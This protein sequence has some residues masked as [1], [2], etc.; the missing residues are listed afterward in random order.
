VL[1]AGGAGYIGSHAAKALAAA[2]FEPVVFD[3]LS[4]GHE[5]AV[6][7]GPLVEASLADRSAI[8]AALNRYDP[9]AV[10]HFA[11]HAYV[12]E[13]VAH[14][15]KYYRN[16]VANTMNLLDAALAHGGLPIVFSSTCA[17]YG[18]PQRLPIDEA[19]PQ[20]PINPYGHTKL[21]VEEM[22][23]AYDAAYGLRSVA[24][25][26]F[27]AA[28]ADPD[29]ELGEEHDDETHLVPLALLTSLGRR[30]HLDVFG[31]DYGTRD[32]TAVRDYIHVSDLASAHVH[33][34]RYLL[35]GGPTT[36]LNLGVGHGYS[37]RDVIDAVERVTGARVPT[38]ERPRRAGDPPALVAD[39]AKARATLGWRP[40][41]SHL[42]EIVETAWRWLRYRRDQDPLGEHVST[43]P[44]A[45]V[46]AERSAA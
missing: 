45:S 42:D 27:N 8:E 3:D 30:P 17:T 44:P 40:E 6:R 4:T 1:V 38:V 23:T 22:L 12:G 5:H 18:I 35:D 7:W 43:T 24:L 31:S 32:G 20:R 39:A 37:V 15:A 28:G 26:Y 14:P 9:V 10:I 19:H 34:L 41:H 13:S 36:A 21:V 2:D 11:A 29:G 25:R 33:A 46:P 16:N